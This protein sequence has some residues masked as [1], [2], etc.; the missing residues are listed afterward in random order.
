MKKSLIA[1][2]A[3]AALLA[4][5]CSNQGGGSKPKQKTLPMP[6]EDVVA[7][8]AEEYEFEFDADLLPEYPSTSGEAEFTFDDSWAPYTGKC[9][10]Y[11]E[12]TTHEE[13]GLYVTYMLEAGWELDGVEED[14]EDLMYYLSAPAFA[15]GDY[16]PSVTVYDWIESSDYLDFYFG[17]SIVADTEFPAEKI[18]ASLATSGVTEEL[19]A[20]TGAAIEY[21]W[22]A[23]ELQLQITVP[24]GTEADEQAGYIAV[25]LENGFEEAYE[26]DYGDV[27]Y[28]S[29][30][31]QLDVCPWISSNYPGYVIVDIIVNATLETLA[32]SFESLLNE[33]TTD[34]E[35]TV[36]EDGTASSFF[37]FVYEGDL[38]SA[39]K[40]LEYT[41]W[42][43]IGWMRHFAP[44]TIGEDSFG[45]PMAYAS[46][47]AGDYTVNFYVFTTEDSETLGVWGCYISIVPTTAYEV[48]MAVYAATGIGFKYYEEYDASDYYNEIA[49]ESSLLEIVTQL[50]S[51]M[52]S[53]L[54][55]E[56]APELRQ[57]SYGDPMGYAAYS[58]CGYTLQIMV[59]Q[60]EEGV[61]AYY[62]SIMV[63]EE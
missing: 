29:E 33:I 1:T 60:A 61:V 32:G 2:I 21:V 19:P 39:A 56:V 18:A 27:H 13:C 42:Y 51:S 6:V 37:E 26:D 25:L 12:N 9:D 47:Y 38:E 54:T 8:Y 59:S 17:L 58:V 28:F 57:D 16:M 48:T 4:V 11:V 5:S 10:V 24:E 45:D 23:S 14:D 20:F 62:M 43:Y 40:A 30:L 46:Q 31:G 36:W 34:V 50:G 35:F 15:Q 3:A 49:T 44:V 22:V 55:V 53:F 7:F 63:V 41:C 52:P